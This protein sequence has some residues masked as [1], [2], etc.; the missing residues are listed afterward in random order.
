MIGGKH[1]A[2]RRR[3]PR[4]YAR[5][6]RHERGRRRRRRRAHPAAA[7]SSRSSGACP[8]AVPVIDVTTIG[9]GGSSIARLRPGRAARGRPAERRRRPG[10]GLLRQ[11]RRR[12]RRSR[13]RT[14]CSGGSTR[15]TS[16]AASSRSTP[17]SRA[18]AL[19]ADRVAARGRARGR[20]AR[21]RRGGDREHGER[22]PAGHRRPRARLPRASTSWR[23]AARGRCTPR[24]S[25]AGSGLAGVDRAARAGARLGVRRARR[26]PARRPRLTRPLRSGPAPA[27]ADLR[28]RSAARGR[29]VAELAGRDGRADGARRAGERPLPRAELRAGGA[30]VPLDAEGDL[31]V[32]ARAERF[33]ESHEAAYGYRSAT[34]GRVVYL[35]RDRDRAARAGAAAPRCA[36]RDGSRRHAAGLFGTPAGST[37]RSTAA[38]GLGAGRRASGPGRSSRS[39]TRRRS[40]SPA[41]RL[42]VAPERLALSSRPRRAAS[43]AHGAT[44]GA[45]A[46]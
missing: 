26:R 36:G 33:H 7:P 1:L 21:G 10:P 28:D 42:R 37:R 12:A 6:G 9:A 4:V 27:D 11:G 13:T 23:S 39:R 31:V 43:A 16:S 14:S 40:S 24:R 29:G 30:S 45:V 44:S 20:R 2:R 32:A 17:T 5:H 38:A 34:P 18:R 8:I 3:P 41:R 35:E 25:R 46:C 15:S 22:G 19:R